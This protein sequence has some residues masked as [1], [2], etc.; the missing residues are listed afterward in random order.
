MRYSYKQHRLHLANIRSVS[1]FFFVD[2][3]YLRDYSLVN[4]LLKAEPSN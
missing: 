3:E 4:R 1:T 2:Q